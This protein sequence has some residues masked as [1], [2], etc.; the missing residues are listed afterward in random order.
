MPLLISNRVGNSK[1]VLEE[2]RNGYVFSYEKEDDAIK[3]I[4]HM[5]NAN[6]EWL[7]DASKASRKKAES[8]YNSKK[9]V[10]R[11]V[12]ELLAML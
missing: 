7:Q 9:N 10:E 2:G 5:I 8:I 6:D 4:E 1:E 11:I 3:K 12:Q